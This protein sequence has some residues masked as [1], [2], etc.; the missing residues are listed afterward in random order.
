[1]ENLAFNK[2][3]L[4]ST[5]SRHQKRH[6]SNS[7]IAQD[8]A[9]QAVDGRLEQGLRFC[10]ILDNLYGDVFAI[11]LG[12]KRKVS[13]VVIYTWQGEGQGKNRPNFL[14]IG[15]FHRILSHGPRCEK[16]CLRSFATQAQTSMRIRADWSAPLLFD[17][18]KEP[19]LNLLQAKFQYSS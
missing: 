4:I 2:R 6:I 5:S 15:L 10:T 3:A 1:M 16:P 19:Y 14:E 17:N 8:R 9:S 13:G 7:H 18:W 12:R 11:D